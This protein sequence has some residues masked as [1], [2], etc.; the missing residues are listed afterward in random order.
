MTRRRALVFA[1]W[2]IVVCPAAGQATTD[3]A[4]KAARHPQA[5]IVSP[6]WVS[7]RHDRDGARRA[8]HAARWGGGIDEIAAAF[9]RQAR[10]ESAYVSALDSWSASG[11]DTLSS[12]MDLSASFLALLR[13]GTLDLVENGR[14]AGAL[15]LLTG[16]LRGDR[17]MLPIRARAVGLRQSPDSGLA[18]LR[19]PPD[20]RAGG[21]RRTRWDDLGRTRG[22]GVEAGYLVAA[23]LADSAHNPRAMR[24]ALWR[25]LDHGRSQAKSVARIRLARSLARRGEMSLAEWLLEGSSG[26]GDDETVLLANLRADLADRRGDSLGGIVRLINAGK[27]AELSTAA[28]YSIVQRAAGSLRAAWVDSLEEGPWLDLVRSLADVGEGEKALSIFKRRRLFPSDSAQGIARGET[29]AALLAKVRRHQEAA[30][31]YRRLLIRT[32]L[33][34]STR[35]KY[36]LG[37]ARARRGAGEFAGMDSAFLVSVALDSLGAT[38]AQAAWERAREWEDRRP[39]Q[40]CIRIFDWARRYIRERTVAQSLMAHAA[41]AC[42]R[43]G[44]PDS[45]LHFIVGSS[46]GFPYYWRAQIHFAKG[47]SAAAFADLGRVP[48]G[49][50]WTYEGLRA[51]EER[52]RH[53]LNP[54]SKSEPRSA[55]DEQRAGGT[56]PELLPAA[57]PDPPFDARLLGAVGATDLMIDALRDCSQDRDGSRAGACVD[58]LEGAGVFRVGSP[59]KLPERRFRYPPAYPVEVLAAARR[60]SLSAALLWAIMRQESAYQRSARSKAGAVGLLQLLPSTASRLNGSTVTEASLTAVELNIALGA[61]YLRDLIVEFGDPRAAIA[62]YNAGEEAVRRWRRERAV[63]DDIWIESIPYRE[64]RDYVKQVYSIW[65]RYEAL[66]GIQSWSGR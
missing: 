56:A 57:D 14:P 21:D 60:E 6:K 51:R 3:A 7:L 24:A 62:A 11:G 55:G 42:I 44:V 35:A 19:W 22:A 32:D 18:L 43:S 17:A 38:A 53:G 66:Y 36:A 65:R 46:E 61:R 58:A 10:A 2:L 1:A 5:R 41:I 29:E 47:D 64:T 54:A 45:G 31:A 12:T 30:D 23:E 16:P 4:L 15:N 48:L 39:P 49:D 13:E 40:E 28:R 50:P 37:L 8:W 9:L 59:G 33:P 34:S 25:L 52:V 20:R 63:V 27:S 26:I